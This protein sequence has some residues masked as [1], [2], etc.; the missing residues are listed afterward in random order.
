MNVV[1]ALL[2]HPKE[3]AVTYLLLSGAVFFQVVFW[4]AAVVAVVN[5]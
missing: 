2:F 5:A 4:V 1:A 3:R